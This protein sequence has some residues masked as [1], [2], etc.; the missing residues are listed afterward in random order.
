V[1][2][3]AALGQL[4]IAVRE[5]TIAN[6][7]AV[8]GPYVALSGRLLVWLLVCLDVR[9]LRAGM[10]RLRNGGT[11]AVWATGSRAE[12]GLFFPTVQAVRTIGKQETE[13]HHGCQHFGKT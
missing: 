8:R 6:E 7:I 11:P 4:P 13:G 12:A 5:E 3:D 1:W 2:P 9:E 10:C